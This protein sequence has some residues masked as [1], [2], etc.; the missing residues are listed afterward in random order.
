MPSLARAFVRGTF[1]KP[2][3]RKFLREWCSD[4]GARVLGARG[5]APLGT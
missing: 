2:L 3:N 1:C 4:L 5:G